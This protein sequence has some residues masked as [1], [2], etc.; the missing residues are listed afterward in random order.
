M[1]SSISSFSSSPLMTPLNGSS[2]QAATALD[3]ANVARSQ[4]IQ[5]VLN[6]SSQGHAASVKLDADGDGDG[7]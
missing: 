1:V 2:S 6:I 4:A 7:H 5:D 3:T